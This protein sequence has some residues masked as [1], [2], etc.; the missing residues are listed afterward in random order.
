[1]MMI[2]DQKIEEYVMKYGH[3][4]DSYEPVSTTP[5]DTI[6][7]IEDVKSSIKETISSIQKDSSDLERNKSI[8]KNY[9]PPGTAMPVFAAVFVLP[10]N[11]TAA[12][13]FVT[14]STKTIKISQIV[15]KFIYVYKEI[16]PC[17]T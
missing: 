5:L 2:I 10:K 13:D 1:M 16:F 14:K 3:N 4:P 15:L 9:I 7:E 17:F 8:L 11:H 6:T 12:S